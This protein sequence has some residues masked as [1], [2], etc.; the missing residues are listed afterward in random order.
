[1][2]FVALPLAEAVADGQLPSGMVAYSLRERVSRLEGDAA[3]AV[4]ADAVVVAQV[5][6]RRALQVVVVGVLSQPPIQEGPSQVV[7]SVLLVLHRLGHHLRVEVVRERPQELRLD[8]QPGVQA[9]QVVWQ[10]TV[11]GDDDPLARGVELRPPGT[12]ETPVQSG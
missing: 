4:A 8:R 9:A 12:A 2:R 5:A 7:D 10:R 3:D 11:R 1:M 6:V